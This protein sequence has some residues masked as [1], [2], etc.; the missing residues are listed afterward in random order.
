MG[1][2][3]WPSNVQRVKGSNVAQRQ[4]REIKV[5][6]EVQLICTGWVAQFPWLAIR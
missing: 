3:G 2:T 4:W 5:R 6:K 1:G